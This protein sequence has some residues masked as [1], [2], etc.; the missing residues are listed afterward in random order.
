MKTIHQLPALPDVAREPSL[1]TEDLEGLALAQAAEADVAAKAERALAQLRASLELVGGEDLTRLE[2]AVASTLAQ[3]DE[4]Q[5]QNERKPAPASLEDR[6]TGGDGAWAW[7]AVMVTV[8]LASTFLW[9][10]RSTLA[11]PPLVLGALDLVLIVAGFFAL[12][13]HWTVAPSAP[14]SP[15][16]RPP[17]VLGVPQELWPDTSEPWRTRL[18]TAQGWQRRLS[19]P[20]TP[21]L[22]SL[23]TPLTARHRDALEAYRRESAAWLATSGQDYLGWER[24]PWPATIRRW[25]WLVVPSARRSWARSAPGPARCTSSEPSSPARSSASSAARC[26]PTCPE[27][28]RFL[29]WTRVPETERRTRCETLRGDAVLADGSFPRRVCL[30]SC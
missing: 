27:A 9:A 10:S 20:G 18:E 17:L 14:R 2:H 21:A 11:L 4:L 7:V 5:K 28:A 25:G 30:P 3:R 13:A 12:T 6:K 26:C 22:V 8:G 16:A 29:L 15:P 24:R 23:L 1:A 19:T